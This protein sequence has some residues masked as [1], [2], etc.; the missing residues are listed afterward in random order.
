MGWEGGY[1]LTGF[2]TLPTLVMCTQIATFPHTRS[3][4]RRNATRYHFWD[5]QVA[6]AMEEFRS[7]PFDVLHNATSFPIPSISAKPET[8]ST[9]PTPESAILRRSTRNLRSHTRSSTSRPTIL[10]AYAPLA[11]LASVRQILSQGSAESF[12]IYPPQSPPFLPN[13]ISFR[14]SSA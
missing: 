1:L 7:I 12:Y 8:L 9:P 11:S 14:S 13:L 4:K 3:E 6:W 5:K 2:K 10:H